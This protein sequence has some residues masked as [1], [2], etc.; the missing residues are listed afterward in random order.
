MKKE[1]NES[2][3][4][5]PQTPEKNIKQIKDIQL[6]RYYTKTLRHIFSSQFV[7]QNINNIPKFSNF[8]LSSEPKKIKKTHYMFIYLLSG[9]KKAHIIKFK[10][11]AKLKKQFLRIKKQH[12]LICRLSRRKIQK[13]LNQILFNILPELYTSEKKTLQIN[14]STVKILIFQTPLIKQSLALKSRSGYLTTIP[15]SLNFHFPHTSLYQKI[16]LLRMMGL[17]STFPTKYLDKFRYKKDSK[18]HK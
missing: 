6:N 12:K 15:L 14:Q 18:L 7:L 9:E 1:I 13:V 11:P 5:S 8:I 16:F 10:V 17:Y 2:S 4:I 3:V